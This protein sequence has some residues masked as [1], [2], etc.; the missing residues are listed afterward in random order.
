MAALRQLADPATYRPCDWDLKTD[1]R[2]RRYWVDLF[3]WHLDAVLVPLICDEY[4]PDRTALAT[5]CEEY[6]R[7]FDDISARPERFARIDVL[8]FTE[9]RAALLYRHHFPDPFR[10]LKQ[11][12]NEIAGALLPSVL[13]ELDAAAPPQ[14]RDLL[15]S[16]L[17]AGNLFD[18]GSR[19]TI[20]RQNETNALFRQTRRQVPA[21]PWFQD[22]LDAW[23]RRWDTRPTYRHAVFFVDN[24]GSDLLLGCLPFV[25]W[26]L[27]RGTR[28]TLAANSRPALNDI[29]AAELTPLLA[30]YAAADT[31]LSQALAARRLRVCETGC[32]TPLIDLTRLADNFVA[33]TT[34]AD[35]LWL[36]GM[37]RAVE[38]NYRAR[39]TCDVVRTAVLKD[40]G[41]A[42]WLGGK[43]FDCLFC[44]RPTC[45][46][47]PRR[48]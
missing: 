43:L 5:F 13:A 4:G 46:P 34:D 45:E 24:A 12:A 44:F 22:D 48:G 40:E 20:D 32:G 7:C 21:R 11:Q 2:G 27:Q 3:R 8:Y 29:T 18:L 26:M 23:W 47:C 10:K 17:M 42:A 15:I 9:V 35:L 28:V 16:G 25:R 30:Q 38:S 41:V 39:F 33:T 31:A 36:H 1:A 37:G 14:Q 19:S 6:R